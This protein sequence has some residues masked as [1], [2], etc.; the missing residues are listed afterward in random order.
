MPE[1]DTQERLKKAQA[2]VKSLQ[3]SRD[4]INRDA[5]VEESKLKEAYVKLREL[6]VENPENMSPKDMQA[7]ADGLRA[8]VE[9]KLAALE[10][11][12]VDGE[13]LMRKYNELQGT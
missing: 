4:Q 3:T 5:A 8:E 12:L 7:L 1:E 6:G 9:Q 10:A 11:Q 13:A 2:L